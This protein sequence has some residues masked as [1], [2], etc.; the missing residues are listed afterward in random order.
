MVRMAVRVRVMVFRAIVMVR[1]AIRVWIMVRMVVRVRVMVRMV[2]RV[3]VT[4]LRRPK[5]S[6]KPRGA[7]APSA[8]SKAI[9]MEELRATRATGANAPAVNEL[10]NYLVDVERKNKE[11]ELF[12]RHEGFEP[13]DIV[14]LLFALSLHCTKPK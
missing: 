13:I 14:P 9:F 1:M 8:D 6:Q 12:L 2:I 3:R 7:W 10:N 11:K 4:S 5:G